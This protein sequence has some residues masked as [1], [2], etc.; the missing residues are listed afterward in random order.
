MSKDSIRYVY[1]G[2]WLTLLAANL[3]LLFGTK[4]PKL[5]RALLPILGGLAVIS[6]LLFLTLADFCREALYLALPVVILITV[7]NLRQFKI[8]DSCASLVRG[9]FFSVPKECHKCGAKLTGNQS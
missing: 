3:F 5:K 4:K 9:D 6:V 8:C 2:I 7:L 1:I